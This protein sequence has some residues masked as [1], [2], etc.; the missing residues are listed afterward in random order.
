MFVGCYVSRFCAGFKLEFERYIMYVAGQ[1]VRV[2]E[3]KSSVAHDPTVTPC[4]L[5]TIPKTQ[6]SKE[7][8]PFEG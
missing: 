8:A 5:S 6:H 7:L 2:C 4:G 3:F 1:N